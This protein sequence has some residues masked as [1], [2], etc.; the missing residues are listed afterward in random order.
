M[1]PR[2][3]E[4]KLVIAAQF[5]YKGP[6]SEL[7]PRLS[8]IKLCEFAS[9][10][11]IPPLNLLDFAVTYSSSGSVLNTSGISPENLFDEMSR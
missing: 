4:A 3:S 5:R 7:F 2:S 1:D 6:V 9:D 10:L 8:E 11:G